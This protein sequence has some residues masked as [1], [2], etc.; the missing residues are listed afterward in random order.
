MVYNLLATCAAA[1]CCKSRSNTS[2]RRSQAFAPDN[3]R[4]QPYHI[5]GRCV[6]LNLAKNPTGFNQNL[7]IVA[8]APG[9]KAVAFFINDKE[10]DGHDV[11][12]LW[13]VDF[14]EL[15]TVDDLVVFAGGIR[16]NDLQVRLKY[17]GID[18][19]ACRRRGRLPREG[20]GAHRCHLFL[21][22]NYTA[23]PDVKAELDEMPG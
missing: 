11:S 1:E 4:L 6:L 19:A 21:I 18:A 22:A 23:L 13:D 12:W 3:G 10:A 5:G 9:P 17:A 14:Q 20:G 2:T 7:R 16:R 15:A 8:D